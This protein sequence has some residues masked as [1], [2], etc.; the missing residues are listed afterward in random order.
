MNQ[1]DFNLLVKQA[2][3]GDPEALQ[4]L[5]KALR[6]DRET[7]RPFGD[8]AG[9]VKRRFL[10]LLTADDVVGRESLQIN[11]AELE[12]SLRRDQASP[13]R[14]LS[15]E[16]VLICWL[17]VRYQELMASDPREGLKYT[18]YLDQRLE[19]ARK[20]Y[21][22]ALKTLAQLDQIL[23]IEPQTAEM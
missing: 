12:D 6:S 5:R 8:L 23:G 4:K 15:I 1:N 7:W 17:D 19:R 13:I 22:K 10:K 9:H 20:R 11:L 3:Q 2:G 16:E 18:R 14:D 21:D